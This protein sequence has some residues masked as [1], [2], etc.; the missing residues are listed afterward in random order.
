MLPWVAVG[1]LSSVFQSFVKCVLSFLKFGVCLVSYYYMSEPEVPC[2][3]FV[4]LIEICAGDRSDLGYLLF[5]TD[6]LLPISCNPFCTDVL[7]K[8]FYALHKIQ[9]LNIFFST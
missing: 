8:F 2:L 6:V 5:L 7:S 9:C 4:P 1:T 3:A